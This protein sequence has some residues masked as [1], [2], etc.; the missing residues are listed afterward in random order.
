[1]KKVRVVLA[2]D[3]VVVREG[4]RAILNAEPG[5]EV[6]GEASDGAGA[7][8]AA[9]RLDPDVVVMDLTMPNV[10]GAQATRQLKALR[11]NVKV[12]A[13]TIHEEG[14]Y[15]RVLLDAG[16][17]GY[18]LKRSPA[19]ELVRAV[20]AVASGGVYLDP[21]MAGTVGG[22]LRTNKIP[23]THRNA[24]L[25]EREEEVVRLLARGYSN[26]EIAGQLDVSV[27][28]VETYRSRAME[29][30]GLR[31]RADLVRHSLQ[32]GWLQEM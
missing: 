19:E 17:S 27:K 13:L 21:S 30:L 6:V 5:L 2:D 1:M 18:V 29:K 8:A 24:D 25:S 4:L 26:K 32:Q 15:L 11:P 14:G 31:S 22:L 23:V 12:V 10:N 20:R 28:T 9:E 16:A 3:H 7:V